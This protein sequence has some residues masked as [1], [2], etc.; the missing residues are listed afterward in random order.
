MKC[1]GRVDAFEV[2]MGPSFSSRGEG[3]ERRPCSS[4]DRKQRKQRIFVRSQFN[5]MTSSC[6][7]EGI[8][9]IR[10]GCAPRSHLGIHPTTGLT[11]RFGGMLPHW[12][13]LLACERRRA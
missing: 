2:K 6:S 8:R 3:R 13:M 4:A 11:I 1:S 9:A 10:C 7:S 12:I 5:S